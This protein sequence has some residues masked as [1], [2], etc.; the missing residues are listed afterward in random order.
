L[1]VGLVWAGNAQRSGDESRSLA[2]GV[3]APLRDALPGVTWF[4]LQAGL[5]ASASRPFAMVDRMADVRDYA[6]TAALI[7]ALDLVISVDT[8]VAHAAA[9]LGKPL[10][11]LAPHNV[12]WRWDMAGQ[13]S[14]W[15]SNVRMFRAQRPNAWEP[16]I[17]S[18]RQAFAAFAAPARP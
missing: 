10:W 3:L 12:C 15:Y 5:D 11:L 16:V 1:K 2:P 14:P 4:S 9:A 6:D 7:D 13:E 17:E 18:V 8:S